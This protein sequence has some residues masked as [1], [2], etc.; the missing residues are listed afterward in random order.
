MY[1]YLKLIIAASVLLNLVSCTTYSQARKQLEDSLPE[2]ERAYLVGKYSVQCQPNSSQTKCAQSFNSI[3]LHYKIDGENKYSD[4]LDSTNG[5]M[6]G[7]DTA[8]DE[9]AY[10]KNEKSYYFCRILPA[11]EYRFFTISFW[12]FAGG[13]S[14]YYL[15]EEDQFNVP[16]KLEAGKINSIGSLKL[17][18]EKGKNI[19]GMPLPAPGV[20]EI[21]P[22]NKDEVELA[23]QK[24]PRNAGALEIKF[25]DLWKAEYDSSF[26]HSKN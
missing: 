23:V 9:I 7:N 20:L 12:N 25:D 18:T 2:N 13:G 22:I 17:T 5:S 3:S 6:F 21:S 26:V 4:R 19:F 1:T 16:F 24:C 14:G 10:D 8:Y 15:S 11:G